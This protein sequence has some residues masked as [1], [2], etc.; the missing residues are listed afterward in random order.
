[1]QNPHRQRYFI[2]ND[3]SWTTIFHGQRYFMD[4]NIS[5]TTILGDSG[6]SGESCDSGETGEESISSEKLQVGWVW[7]VRNGDEW[8]VGGSVDSSPL[9]VTK[10]FRK[11]LVWSERSYCGQQLGWLACGQ[12]T[13]DGRNVNIKI[14]FCKSEFAIMSKTAPLIN[15]FLKFKFPIRPRPWQ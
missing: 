9:L 11:Y 7:W 4:N 10:A 1:M 12:Q 6:V 8:V 14:E 3:I 13:S 5:S 15:L 2:D